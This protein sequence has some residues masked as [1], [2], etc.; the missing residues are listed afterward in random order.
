MLC[1]SEMRIFA[2][3][4]AYLFWATWVTVSVFPSTVSFTS[5]RQEISEGKEYEMVRKV[6]RLSIVGYNGYIN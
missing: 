6:E 4:E 3:N 2:F 5:L 1:A